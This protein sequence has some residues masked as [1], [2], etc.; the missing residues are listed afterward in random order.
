M[1]YQQSI[2]DNNIISGHRLSILILQFICMNHQ[3][4]IQGIIKRPRKNKFIVLQE[5]DTKKVVPRS[6]VSDNN[7]LLETWDFK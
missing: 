1:L 7:V 6:S 3:L 2:Q 5:R 4:G